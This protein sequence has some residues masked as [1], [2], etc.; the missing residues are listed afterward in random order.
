MILWHM[1]EVDQSFNMHVQL[2]S[3]ARGLNFGPMVLDKNIDHDFKSINKERINPYHADYFYELHSPPFF[4][5]LTCSITVMH[6]FA[7]I[8]ETVDPDQKHAQ[9]QKVLPEAVQ[10]C[11][12]FFS[13]ER[14]QITL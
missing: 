13:D 4:I 12:I 6:A 7:S 9:I 8:E 1:C 14:I 2:T 11:N 3:G 10:L 5:L